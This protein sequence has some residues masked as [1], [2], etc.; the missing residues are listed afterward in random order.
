MSD[1]RALFDYFSGCTGRFAIAGD[2]SRDLSLVWSLV[3]LEFGV[4]RSWYSGISTKQILD[5][6]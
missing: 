1:F 3:I 4:S 6:D 5:W 2:I